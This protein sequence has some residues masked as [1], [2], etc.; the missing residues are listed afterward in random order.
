MELPAVR[1]AL[2]AAAAALLAAAILRADPPATPPTPRPA[3]DWT[4]AVYSTRVKDRPIN[5]IVIHTIE[6]SE[7]SAIARFQSGQKLLSAHYVVGRDGHITQMVQDAD[8]AWHAGNWTYNRQSIGIEHEGWA[9][10]KGT[11]AAATYQASAAL[12]RWLCDTYA[13]PID[14]EHILGHVE[15]PK[16]THTDPGPYWD[17]DLYLRLVKAA[18]TSRPTTRIAVQD[19]GGPVRVTFVVTNP[20]AA[21]LTLAFTRAPAFDFTLTTDQGREV[22]R[23]SKGRRFGATPPTPRV[24]APGQSLYLSVLARPAPGL[25]R[26]GHYLAHAYVMAAPLLFG[27]AGFVSGG[28]TAA[29]AAEAGRSDLEVGVFAAGVNPADPTARSLIEKVGD[30]GGN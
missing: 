29:E 14:R 20:G 15:I 30:L 19:E 17:W 3:T 5:Y 23:W 24:L 7:A 9:H 6:G 22:W 28:A 16:A 8:A 2:A 18:P 25:R 21:P 4:P 11:I 1:R 10:K 13:V 12:T 26:G 27:S